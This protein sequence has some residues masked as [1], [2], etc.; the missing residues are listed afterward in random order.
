MIKLHALNIIY[1]FIL[2]MLLQSSGL[3]IIGYRCIRR[4]LS[5]VSSSEF[6]SH[7]YHNNLYIF[8]IQVY[9]L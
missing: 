2:N 3:Q 8:M 9:N 7:T 6:V 5:N 1:L 4:G